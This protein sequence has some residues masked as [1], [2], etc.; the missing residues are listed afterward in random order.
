MT[1][2]TSFK[3]IIQSHCETYC[4]KIKHSYLNYTTITGVCFQVGH[5]IIVINN[6]K[7]V[8]YTHTNRESEYYLGG[9]GLVILGSFLRRERK[10]ANM[11]CALLQ[12][13]QFLMN[14][15]ESPFLCMHNR[16]CKHSFS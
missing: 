5:H 10:I 13:A 1:T 9:Y 14:T 8:N 15:A 11:I 16:N 2:L 3:N 12:W 7:I 4:N 6:N